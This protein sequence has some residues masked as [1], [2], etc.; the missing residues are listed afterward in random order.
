[1]EYCYTSVRQGVSVADDRN[2][3]GGYSRIDVQKGEIVVN[4][5]PGLFHL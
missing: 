3:N 1:M 4:L 2:E 5:F